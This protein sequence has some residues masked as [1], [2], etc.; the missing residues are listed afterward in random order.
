MISDNTSQPNLQFSRQKP[1]YEIMPVN[2]N[3]LG[4]HNEMVP[5][6]YVP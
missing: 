1:P 3:Y 4:S 2:Y 5:K 6:E